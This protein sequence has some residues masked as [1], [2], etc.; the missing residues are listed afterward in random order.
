MKQGTFEVVGGTWVEFDGNVPNG[1]SMNRQFLYGQHFFEDEFGQKPK[2]FFL[3]DTFGYSPQLPQIAKNAEIEYFITQKL[4]WSIFN[5]FPNHTFY[6]KGIDGTEIFSHFPPADTYVSN[7]S[8]QEILYNVE[9]NN[10]KGRTN[11]SLLLFGD[12]DGGGGPQLSH[13][14]K[15]IR[16]KDF[17]GIPKVKFSTCHEFFEEA[18]A[19]SKKLMTWEGELYL[20]LHNGTFTTMAEHKYYNRYMETLLK[21]VEFFHYLSTLTGNAISDS[22]ETHDAIKSMWRTFLIDQFHDVLPGTCTF[23]TV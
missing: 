13:V 2:I 19:T 7:G 4:S 10:D 21:D 5:K 15:L 3:P 23:L 8:V 14:E 12:G 6:W 1:E 16:A 18:K 17:D 9:K 20:E 22:N 11:S